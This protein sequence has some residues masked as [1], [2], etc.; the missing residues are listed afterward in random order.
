MTAT[1]RAAGL[2]QGAADAVQGVTHE[3]RS[4]DRGHG[5]SDREAAAHA[6]WEA[7]LPARNQWERDHFAKL[8]VHVTAGRMHLEPG[9]KAGHR[10]GSGPGSRGGSS[11]GRIMR[12]GGV[13]GGRAPQ[14]VADP[15][16]LSREMDRAGYADTAVEDQGPEVE[17][18]REPAT[19]A[20]AWAAF[21]REGPTADA[22]RSYLAGGA[23]P[24]Y[25]TPEA[26]AEALAD[27]EAG[28]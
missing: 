4:G 26:R 10:G 24:R 16:E 9:R 27:R 7:G 2:L 23:Q 22:V 17:G 12:G 20:E 11:G 14:P 6:R 25:D 13:Y 15:G 5:P 21:E 28:S 18:H 1:D 3:V 19:L 8:E